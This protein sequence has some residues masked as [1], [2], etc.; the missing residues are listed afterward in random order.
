MSHSVQFNQIGMAWPSW[1]SEDLDSE[2]VRGSFPTVIFC[3]FVCMCVSPL[4]P[5]IKHGGWSVYLRP[6]SEEAE[7]GAEG[8]MGT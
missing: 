2:R 5:A 8:K 4:L 7:A 1:Y 3:V 6:S